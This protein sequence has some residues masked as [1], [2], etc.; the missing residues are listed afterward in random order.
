MRV[1]RFR[2]NCSKLVSNSQ[3]QP[4]NICRASLKSRWYVRLYFMRECRRRLHRHHYR[5]YMNVVRNE[6]ANAIEPRLS[7]L[8]HVCGSLFYWDMM[9][10]KY[11]SSNRIVKI[12][13]LF[14]SVSL[15]AGVFQTR[16]K[17]ASLDKFVERWTATKSHWERNFFLKRLNSETVTRFSVRRMQW[18]CLYISWFQTPTAKNKHFWNCFSFGFSKQISLETSRCAR[19]NFS[20][21]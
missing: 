13:T 9:H 3:T 6:R 18:F 15:R 8:T 17:Y 1:Q 14:F 20:L 4:T 5:S 11:K 21:E 10:N 7:L 16:K 12:P 19:Y 2:S